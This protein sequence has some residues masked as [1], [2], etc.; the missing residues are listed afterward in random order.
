MEE[1]INKIDKKEN[2]NIN[3]IALKVARRINSKEIKGY[4]I[5]CIAFNIAKNVDI[6]KALDILDEI[7]NDDKNHDEALEEIALFLINY[8]EEE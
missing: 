4:V 6:D 5:R 3:E 7:K 1:S 8:E 2:V